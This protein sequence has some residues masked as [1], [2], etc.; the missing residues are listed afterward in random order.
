MFRLCVDCVHCLILTRL[1]V[2]I[3]INKESKSSTLNDRNVCPLPRLCAVINRNFIFAC[4]PTMTTL[5]W[6]RRR[7]H[8]LVSFP[9]VNSTDENSIGP[10]LE[11]MHA[12]E[13]VQFT[14][15]LIFWYYFFFAFLSAADEWQTKERKLK[16]YT[17]RTF[18]M[19]STGHLKCGRTVF[20]VVGWST[21]SLSMRTKKQFLFS[22]VIL[23]TTG[24]IL[25]Y[26]CRY[27]NC[28]WTKRAYE[29]AIAR[30]Q[31]DR[32]TMVPTGTCMNLKHF[33]P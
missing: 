4:R 22:I 32:E 17:I 21:L 28:G 18:L 6:R 24:Y 20:V 14:D 29:Q 30:P 7:L 27:A 12:V 15:C 2:K 9:Y 16:K 5:W 13:L 8:V 33:N 31:R 25:T 11:V 26:L 10:T 23:P 3:A 19:T 1:P